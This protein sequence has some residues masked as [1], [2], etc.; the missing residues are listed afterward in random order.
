MKNI[1]LILLNKIKRDYRH[2]ICIALTLISI[3][4][5][6][7]FPNG[8][9]RL[10]ETVRDLGLSVAYYFCEIFAPN[11]NPITPTVLHMPEWI[12]T[13][14]IWEP[15]KLFPW[16]WEEFKVLWGLYWPV[17]FSWDNLL[18]YFELLGDIAYY[19]SRFALLAVPLIALAHKL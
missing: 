3:G 5:G 8:L 6:F 9:P 14:D 16:T 12:W 13:E 1:I 2:I 19:G 11:A 7:L 18:G 4:F 10:A 15:L 17:F